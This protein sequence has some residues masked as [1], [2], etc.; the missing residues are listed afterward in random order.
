MIT[1]RNYF[2]TVDK[3]EEEHLVD[4][5]ERKNGIFEIDIDGRKYTADFSVAGDAVYSIIVDGKSYSMDID[6]KGDIFTI[7]T[8]EGDTFDVEVLDE[9][10]RLMK[11]RS[12]AGLEGRQVIEAQMP[13]YIWKLLVEPGQEVEAGQPLMILVAMK[14]ENE[15]KAPKAGVVQDIF[16]TLDQTVATGDKLAVVE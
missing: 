7:L 1:K 11:M 8:D 5:T 2:V 4:L 10:K 14:M 9:M 13:G 3:G 6:E 16:V 15:I 12:T